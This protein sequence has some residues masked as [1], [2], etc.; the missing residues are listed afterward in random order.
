MNNL[1]C[2][3]GCFRI[4]TCLHSSN[5]CVLCD[6]NYGY[7]NYNCPKRVAV[8]ATMAKNSIPKIRHLAHMLNPSVTGIEAR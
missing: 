5:N 8:R 2:K 4:E 6:Y 7:E 3:S 1:G